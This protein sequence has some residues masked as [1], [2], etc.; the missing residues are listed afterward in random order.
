MSSTLRG[1]LARCDPGL[2]PKVFCQT[3]GQIAG[4]IR[5]SSSRRGARREGLPA[6]ASADGANAD[7]LPPSSRGTGNRISC[8]GLRGFAGTR[9]SDL[10]P[11]PSEIARAIRLIWN[12]LVKLATFFIEGGSIE[13]DRGDCRDG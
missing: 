11:G 12:D 9:D 8:A 7:A 4:H 13:G 1:G 3:P 2:A 5:T 10:K 6:A